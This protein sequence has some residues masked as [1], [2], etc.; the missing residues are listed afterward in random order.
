MNVL[1]RRMFQAGGPSDKLIQIEPVNSELIRYYVQQGYS[2]LQIQEVYPAANLGIIE[3]IAREEG[4]SLNPAVSL[5]ESFTGSPVVTPAQRADI[6]A[7]SISTPLGNLSFEASA[8]PEL[9]RMEDISVVPKS[10][11]DYITN[12]GGVLDR[13]NLVRGLGVSFGMSEAEANSAID[14][15]TGSTVPERTTVDTPGLP[16]LADVMTGE[17]AEAASSVLGPNQYRDSRGNINKIDSEKFKTFIGGLSPTEIQAMFQA[18][19][20]EYGQELKNIL[21]ARAA[22]V[23][24]PASLF[25]PR[26]EMIGKPQLNAP[27]TPGTAAKEYAGVLKDLGIET[28]EELYNLGRRGIGALD[29]F[30]KSQEEYEK[31]GPFERIDFKTGRFKELDDPTDPYPTSRAGDIERGFNILGAPENRSRFLGSSVDRGGQARFGMSAD[32]LDSLILQSS[33]GPAQPE[34]TDEITKEIEELERQAAPVT[35]TEIVAGETAAT[36]EEI[37][38]AEAQAKAE[39][40]VLEDAETAP[41]TEEQKKT[42]ATP[43]VIS[44]AST[45]E[46]VGSI[47]NSPDFISYVANVS[48]GIAKTGEVGSG[49]ALGSALAAEERSLRDLE[50]EK[51]DRELLL[52][53]IESGGSGLL[54]PTAAA[55]IADQN[56]E[57]TENIK[58]FQK[59]QNNVKSVDEVIKIVKAGGATGLPGLFSKTMT[60]AMVALGKGPKDWAKLDP[61]SRADAIL[62]VLQ[63]ENIRD[64]LG[65]SGR[66]ISNLDREV[67]KDV[68]GNIT[69][70][71]SKAEILEKLNNSRTKTLKSA[72]ETK[73]NINTNLNFF[74]LIGRPSVVA[75]QNADLLEIIKSFDTEN[76]TPS[77]GYTGDVVD[78]DM[79]SEF[80]Q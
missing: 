9:P 38:D 39:E 5:G 46:Q 79:R 26:P 42:D 22:Q 67:I 53:A 35:T 7:E 14:L 58:L 19:D 71:T 15:V 36:E 63:Q 18:P 61:R 25:D 51:A 60:Q 70:T 52:K 74:E 62:K 41:K 50:K 72:N 75:Q 77:T 34:V 80:N 30:F 12:A 33:I 17:Q 11:R 29:Y 65:E 2:P 31:K 8:E 73:G 64:I 43:P 23:K 28:A 48:K 27:I 47:F 55:K 1:Q 59:S 37:Q 44:A 21:S 45:P 69:F 3:Q 56:K 32:E 20:V 13:A 78:I 66:T 68:F 49:I 6:I 4:G 16:G 54:E 24:T 57:L 10:V 40:K 76:Y